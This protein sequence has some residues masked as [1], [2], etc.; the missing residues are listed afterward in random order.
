[1]ALALKAEHFRFGSNAGKPRCEHIFSA[2]PP[3]A[4]VDGPSQNHNLFDIAQETG[5]LVDGR[6]R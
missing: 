2:V 5:K 4:E 6:R 1:M 3:K